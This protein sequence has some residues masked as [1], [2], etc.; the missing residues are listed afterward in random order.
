MDTEYAIYVKNPGALA[1]SALLN[2]GSANTSML[3][4]QSNSV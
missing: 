4:T 3:P 2:A 1:L